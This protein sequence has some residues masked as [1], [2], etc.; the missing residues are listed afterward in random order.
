MTY[1]SGSM[2][3]TKVKAGDCCLDEGDADLVDAGVDLRAPLDDALS[4]G[5]PEEVA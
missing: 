2:S 3:Q 5:V 1:D 4:G